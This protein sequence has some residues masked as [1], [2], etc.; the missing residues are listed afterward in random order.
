MEEGEVI[1][2][3]TGEAVSFTNEDPSVEN[4]PD[5]DTFTV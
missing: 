5:L 3:H 2:L 4:V 1:D